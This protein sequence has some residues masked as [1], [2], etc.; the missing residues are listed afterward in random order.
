M[1]YSRRRHIVDSVAPSESTSA[2]GRTRHTLLYLWDFYARFM[3][4]FFRWY[5]SYFLVLWR[6][7]FSFT[8]FFFFLL[9]VIIWNGTMGAAWRWRGSTGSA[10]HTLALQIYANGLFCRHFDIN[11][12]ERIKK[13]TA[14][15]SIH[16][17][18]TRHRN[19]SHTI[20]FLSAFAFF[21]RPPALVM[22]ALMNDALIWAGDSVT[23]AEPISF[24]LLLRRTQGAT[25]SY[26]YNMCIHNNKY[27]ML[28]FIWRSIRALTHT[29]THA[30]DEWRCRV[31]WHDAKH[32]CV[33]VC[34]RVGGWLWWP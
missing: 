20:F 13:S 12:T 18:R 8:F 3:G 4:I 9:V 11:E 21:L 29:R 31:M 2:P 17:Y 34:G 28:L 16:E 7:S 1:S 22:C 23:E 19:R 10:R 27:V 26:T 15:S 30:H 25:A 14:R 32:V 5:F 6:D 24:L 33:C